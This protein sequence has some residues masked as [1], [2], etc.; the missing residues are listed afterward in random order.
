MWLLVTMVLT[1]CQSTLAHAVHTSEGPDQGQG[2]KG[3]GKG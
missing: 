1:D 3:Q 2:N